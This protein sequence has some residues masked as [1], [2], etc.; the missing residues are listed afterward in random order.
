[1]EKVERCFPDVEGMYYGLFDV[2]QLLW[3]AVISPISYL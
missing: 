3:K 1:M 2:V